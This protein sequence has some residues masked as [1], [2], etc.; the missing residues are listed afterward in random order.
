MV[1]FRQEVDC[2]VRHTSRLKG[3]RGG[4]RD[5]K[6]SANTWNLTVNFW[7]RTANRITF[8]AVLTTKSQPQNDNQAMK[9]SL[10]TPLKSPSV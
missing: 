9:L 5:R 3:G 2:N 4:G 6:L 1:L 10:S 7:L 8:L